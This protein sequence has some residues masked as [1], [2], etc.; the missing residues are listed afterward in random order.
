VAAAEEV[1]VHVGGLLPLL[2]MFTVSNAR[3]SR[4]IMMVVVNLD[5]ASRGG[6]GA[7]AVDRAPRGCHCENQEE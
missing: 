3:A 2:A 4:L 1:G 6:H 5:V 7:A